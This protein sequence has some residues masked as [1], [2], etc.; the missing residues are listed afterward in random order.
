M[1][2]TFLVTLLLIFLVS[3]PMLYDL[4]KS[5]HKKRFRQ[6]VEAGIINGNIT[7]ND[8]LSISERWGQN[9]KTIYAN[10]RIMLSEAIAVENKDLSEKIDSIRDLL[11]EHQCKEPFAEL[12]EEISLQLSYLE[13]LTNNKEKETITQLAASLSEIYRSNQEKVS[14][15]R[16]YT[17]GGFVIGFLGLLVGLEDHIRNWINIIF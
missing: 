11:N 12:P 8:M 7:Y 1:I 16:K 15:Q 9:R 4:V 2:I 17:L 6:Q 5:H 3:L 14:T 10:L 13:T